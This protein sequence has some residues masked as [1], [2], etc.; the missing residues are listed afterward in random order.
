MFPSAKLIYKPDARRVPVFRKV[1]TATDNLDEATLR[2]SALGTFQVFLN[3][4]KIGDDVLSPGWTSYKHRIGAVT[5]TIED[6]L[7]LLPGENL[8]EI[9]VTH[10]WYSGRISLGKNAPTMP[11][12]V[13]AELKM[14]NRR[15]VTNTTWEAA[16]SCI[17]SSDIYDGI[18][19]DARLKEEFGKVAVLDHFDKSLFYP[20]YEN[21]DRKSVV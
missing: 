7:V 4:E 1:F 16:D 21:G 11:Q 12:A 15:V 13:I 17:L 18:V 19:C 6:G 8:L 3:G 2:V 9:I 10:G 5:Y 20:I 14:G